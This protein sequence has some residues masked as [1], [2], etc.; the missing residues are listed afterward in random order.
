[1][2]ENL[3]NIFLDISSWHDSDENNLHSWCEEKNLHDSHK[4]SFPCCFSLLFSSTGTTRPTKN[5]NF[6]L[7]LNS[8]IFK[9]LPSIVKKSNEKLKQYL[10]II[11]I[12]TTIG[13]F[14]NYQYI[15]KL[16]KAI[17][18]V[19]FCLD[20]QILIMFKICFQITIYDYWFFKH[21]APTNNQNLRCYQ[22]CV[23]VNKKYY[24]AEWAHLILIIKLKM[25]KMHSRRNVYI[26]SFSKKILY[27]NKW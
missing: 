6:F 2:H 1:M 19:F 20:D 26:Y 27:D 25:T 10:S 9:L 12:K 14:F 22:A 15:K 18:C 21:I 13:G 17:Y 11:T 24:V 7:S 16:I 8:I 5:G 4:K 23:H 3:T